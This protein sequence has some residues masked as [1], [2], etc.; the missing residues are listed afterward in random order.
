MLEVATDASGVARVTLARPEKRNA[1]DDAVVAALAQAFL[2]FA[3]NPPRVVVLA[4][5]G[6]VFCAGADAD[7]MR[8]AASWPPDVNE[9]DASRLADMLAAVDS[10][11][12]PVVAVVHGAAVGGGAGLVACADLAVAHPDTRFAFSEV[13][14]GLTPATISPFVIRA[15][16]ARAARRWF[17]TGERF[18]AAEALRLGLIHAVADPPEGMARAWIEALLEGAPGAVAEA[19]RL[20]ADVAGRVP[21]AALRAE[22]ARRIAARRAT[23]E[24]REGLSALLERRRPSWSPRA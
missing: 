18:D 24:A 13:R 10:C 11:P 15:I 23:A 2:T 17:L 21:D 19:K 4:G 6:P 12:C 22:T 20:V 14:L 3:S 5:A 1:F 16:G 8:R 9:A 7:W